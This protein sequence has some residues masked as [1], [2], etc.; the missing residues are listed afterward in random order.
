MDYDKLFKGVRNMNKFEKTIRQFISCIIPSKQLRQIIRGKI[1]INNIQNNGINNKIK[2]PK[3]FKNINIKLE[4]NNNS[5]EVQDAR[6]L[7][8]VLDIQITGDNNHVEIDSFANFTGCYNITLYGNNSNICSGKNLHTFDFLN[9]MIGKNHPNFGMVDNVNVK[10]GNDISIE[11]LNAYTFNSN[12]SI[13]VGDDCMIARNVILYHTDS[14]PVYDIT[15]NEIIN[16]VRD[17][18]IGN[19]V[20][21]GE[22]AVILKNVQVPNGCIVGYNSV[23]AKSFNEDNIVIAGNPAKKTKDNIEWARSDS[24]YIKNLI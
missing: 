23:V 6:E 1:L 11:T 17:M 15:S 5:V 12:S 22:N 8:G 16:K 19:H 13:A 7:L 10:L 21:L 18:N 4:G 2:L 9:I 20:W 3:T 14:H 24:E